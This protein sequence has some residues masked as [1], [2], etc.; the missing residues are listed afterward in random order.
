MCFVL[1]F[2][3]LKQIQ[4]L[5]MKLT[6]LH[7][8]VKADFGCVFSHM[9]K[10]W[11]IAF[12]LKMALDFEEFGSD[13]LSKCHVLELSSISD[14]VI[15]FST[16]IKIIRTIQAKWANTICNK[17]IQIYQMKQKKMKK[18]KTPNTVAWSLWEI[19]K[20][21][22]LNSLTPSA[23]VWLSYKD[24]VCWLRKYKPQILKNLEQFGF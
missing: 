17:S 23:H 2:V 3:E 5:I 9:R 19:F 20:W 21:S 18:K 24:I 22:P 6:H 8:N 16:F 13:S 1:L 4:I 12:E 7:W 15:N 10:S 14:I 11:I